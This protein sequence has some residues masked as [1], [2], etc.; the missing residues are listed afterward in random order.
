LIMHRATVAALAA[1]GTLW[2]AVLVVGGAVLATLG[3][4]H[5][6]DMGPGSLLAGLTAVAAGEFVFLAIVGDRLFPASRR[7]LLGA[8]EL[9]FGGAFVLGAIGTVAALLAAG[10]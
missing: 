7:T 1:L 10:A 9:I 8:G 5:W 4:R 2:A 6:P 3:P